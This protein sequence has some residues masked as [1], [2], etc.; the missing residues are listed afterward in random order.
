MRIPKDL[1][2]V[3]FTT[4]PVMVAGEM[5]VGEE[6]EDGFVISVYRVKPGTVVDVE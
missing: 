4:T 3:E 5:E 2:G 1:P 6:V